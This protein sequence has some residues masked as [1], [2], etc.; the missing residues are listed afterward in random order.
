M[1]SKKR[2]IAQ[3]F[4][5]H[6]QVYPKKINLQKIVAQKCLSFVPNKDY[7]LIL[8][9]GA[10]G[11][12]L[13]K[14]LV[15]NF[16][17]KKI[18]FLDMALEML[19]LCPCGLKIL[20]DGEYLPFKPKS[21]NLILSSSTF[22]WYDNG[23]QALLSTLNLLKKDGFFSFAFFVKGTLKE[24]ELASRE[25]GFG[26]IYPLKTTHSYLEKIKKSSLHF[27][28][29]EEEQKIYFNSVKD[30]LLHLKHTGTSY[31]EKKTNFGPKKLKNFIE[32][33]KKNFFS[34][35]GYFITYKTLYLWG[36]I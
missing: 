26:S 31:T 9:I 34:N 11:G 17:Y 32:F 13:G 12:I 5:K 2:Q 1:Y 36:Q 29:K 35:K 25:T 10:G 4:N 3:T 33:Y 15:A 24:I 8:E 23:P 18:I 20:A 27:N 7:P 16:K 21:F 19:K 28:F 22:Q 6:A 14:L 30:I